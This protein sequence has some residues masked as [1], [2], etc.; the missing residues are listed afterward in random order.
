MSIKIKPIYPPGILVHYEV[1]S[2]ST[3][4]GTVRPITKGISLAPVGWYW[5]N[6]SRVSTSFSSKNEAIKDCLKLMTTH[7]G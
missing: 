2:N 5:S 3:Y 4:I 1:W 6:D 7:P